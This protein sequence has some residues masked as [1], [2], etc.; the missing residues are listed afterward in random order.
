MLYM[1]KM[2]KIFFPLNDFSEERQARN[3]KQLFGDFVYGNF[4]GNLAWRPYT[5]LDRYYYEVDGAVEG[6]FACPFLCNYFIFLSTKYHAF[7]KQKNIIRCVPYR[8]KISR[9]AC[10]QFLGGVFAESCRAGQCCQFNND[11]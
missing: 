6:K 2:T 9:R 1:H 11:T 3:L 4:P 5:L 7:Y 10:L 8:K